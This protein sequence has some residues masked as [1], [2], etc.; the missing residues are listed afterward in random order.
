MSTPNEFPDPE[1]GSGQPWRQQP[2]RQQGYQ[3]HPPAGDF[4][5]EMPRDMPSSMQDVLPAGGLA[6]IFTTAGLPQLL[7][8]S[9]FMWLAT[10]GMWLFFT[11]FA[12]IGSFFLLVAR[13]FRGDGLMGIVTSIVSVVLIAA[14]VVCAMKLKEGKLWARMALSAILVAGFLMMFVGGTGGGLLGVAAAVLMWLPESS[15]WLN[16]R[17]K[18]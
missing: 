17:S 12:F 7:K 11:F 2:Y 3:Q 5:F 6:G 16:S 14:I 4:K 1:Q 18:A 13:G 9:Y 15:A 10:A 8:I